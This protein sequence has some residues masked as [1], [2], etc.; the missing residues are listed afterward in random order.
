MDSRAIFANRTGMKVYENALASGT[1]EYSANDL[2]ALVPEIGSP[3]IVRLAVQRQPDTRIH[4]IRSDGTVALLVIDKNEDVTAWCEID[5]LGEV[6]DVVV[7]PAQSGVTDDYIYYVVKR[8]ID[9]A[10]VRYLEKWS[11]ASQSRGGLGLGDAS[12]LNA[13]STFDFCE[14]DV[15]ATYPDDTVGAVYNADLAEIYAVGSNSDDVSIHDEAT[16]TSPPEVVTGIG[17]IESS[18]ALTLIGG[19]S[20]EGGNLWISGRFTPNG[21]IKVMNTTTHVL[22]DMGYIGLNPSYFLAAQ[23]TPSR[24]WLG[25]SSTMSMYTPSISGGSLGAAVWTITNVN[26]DF[27]SGFRPAV[28]DSNN[29]LW[30]GKQVPAP[31]TPGTKLFQIVATTGA[32]AI[33]DGPLLAGSVLQ[34]KSR[35][36]YDSVTQKLYV[37]VADTG[38]SSPAYLYAYSGWSTT[39]TANSGT[40]EQL[41]TFEAG[42]A[43]Y[44]RWIHYDEATDVLFMAYRADAASGR[45][46]I[47]RYTG[48][49]KVL[50]D[51]VTVSLTD[52][53]ADIYPWNLVPPTLSYQSNYGYVAVK[54]ASGGNLYLVKITYGGP[55]VLYDSTGTLIVEG[56]TDD[57]L[58]NLADSYVNYSGVATDTVTGLDHLE[59]EDVV[60]WADGVDLGTDENYEQTYTVA[61]GEITLPAATTNITVGLPYYARFKSSKLMLQTQT[62]ILFG[63]ERRITGLALVLADTHAKGIRFGP[64]YDTLDDRPEMDGWAPVD[65]DNIDTDYDADMI[66]FP[67]TWATDLRICLKAQAP[68]PCTVLAVKLVAEV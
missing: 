63:K 24:V 39:P 51:T 9:G 19:L 17:D 43:Y 44:G 55:E 35:P 33:H 49:P 45:A 5:T 2:C 40:W 8:T 48:N 10:T 26:F 25:Y 18:G 4:C 52:S 1:L 29:H 21:P 57:F 27:N 59:G 61:N 11:Q 14:T 42:G 12:L 7:L 15:N 54:A 67:S 65:P 34:I 47:Y 20:K 16:F 32:Y 68:R 60:V 31:T 46:Y 28:W 37:I 41:M 62:E 6:E 23:D 13:Y 30:L 56:T 64:D 22:T 50:V 38:S 3:G 36:A 53:T 58:N 66:Q